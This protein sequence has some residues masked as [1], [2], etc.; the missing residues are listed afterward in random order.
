MSVMSLN[1]NTASR[2]GAGFSLM[3]QETDNSIK[4][5]EQASNMLRKQISD[6]KLGD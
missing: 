6:I 3:D 5:V 1:I 4:K 2:A